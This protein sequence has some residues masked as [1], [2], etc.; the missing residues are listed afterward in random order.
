MPKQAGRIIS[1]LGLGR[2]LPGS[3]LE[4]GVCELS[5]LASRSGTVA[6]AVRTSTARREFRKM[7]CDAKLPGNSGR[8]LQGSND[9]LSNISN[10]S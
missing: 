5:T 4:S 8:E 1:A 7:G 6:S 3:L 9:T 10:M 2:S